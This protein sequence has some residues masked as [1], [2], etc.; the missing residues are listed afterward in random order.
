MYNGH[1]IVKKYFLL[2]FRINVI[3]FD[4]FLHGFYMCFYFLVRVYRY[5]N[6]YQLLTNLY[7]YHITILLPSLC[8]T[9]TIKININIVTPLHGDIA[10]HREFNRHVM[11]KRK[12]V[13]L[14]R[15]S[16]TADEWI[17]LSLY[18]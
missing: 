1:I 17:A 16:P 14:I 7:C 3:P 15:A 6:T 11:R 18:Y 13:G 12:H 4:V 8:V 9:V 2:S 5:I 10:L